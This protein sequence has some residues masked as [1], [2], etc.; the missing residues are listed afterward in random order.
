MYFSEFYTF[1]KYIK[2]HF[3]RNKALPERMSLRGV[4]KVNIIVSRER[5]TLFLQYAYNWLYDCDHHVDFFPDHEC[6]YVPISFIL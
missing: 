3:I 5:K 2:I 6:P 4:T 1:Y